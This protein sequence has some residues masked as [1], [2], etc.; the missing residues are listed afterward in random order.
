MDQEGGGRK[1]RTAIARQTRES[2][3]TS[4]FKH[5]CTDGTEILT[6]LSFYSAPPIVI[7]FGLESAAMSTHGV[8]QLPGL[9]LRVGVLRARWWCAGLVPGQLVY[10]EPSILFFFCASSVSVAFIGPNFCCFVPFSL[11]FLRATGPRCNPFTSHLIPL[12][13]LCTIAAVF[14]V[15]VHLPFILALILFRWRWRYA[16]RRHWG[17]D[18]SYSG[19]TCDGRA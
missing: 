13:V 1:Q 16:I 6:T 9:Q 11:H 19:D 5:T 8:G 10:K 14:V 7:R 3:I 4:I 2:G 15:A 17:D 18:A 12:H